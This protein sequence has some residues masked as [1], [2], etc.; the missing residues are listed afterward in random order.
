MHCVSWIFDELTK[1]CNHFIPV[2]CSPL[3]GPKQHLA[4]HYDTTTPVLYQ[5]CS[6][7]AL[8]T[9]LH[10]SQILAKHDDFLSKFRKIMPIF[11]FW[12]RM[13]IF[14]KIL[15]KIDDFSKNLPKFEKS[16]IFAKIMIFFY[17]FVKVWKISNFSQSFEKFIIFV[18]K[19]EIC[20]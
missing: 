15:A 12:Q 3:E 16:S 11:R 5:C 19:S 17:F 20:Y 6:A 13:M 8:K 14:F 4:Q 18:P 1:P 10:M 7:A 9:A 2:E